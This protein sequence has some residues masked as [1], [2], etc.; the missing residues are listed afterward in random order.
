MS[1]PVVSYA[2]GR[3]DRAAA[4][5]VDPLWLDDTRRH[6]DSRVVPMWHDKCLVAGSDPIIA[7]T[8]DAQALL[9]APWVFLGLDGAGG[10]FAAD[11]SAFDESDA[12]RLTGASGALD[13]RHLVGSLTGPTSS[14]IAHARG[15]LYWHRNQHFCGRCGSATESSASG[16]VRTCTGETCGRLLFPRIEPAVIALVESPTDPAR[17]LLGRANGADEDSFCTLAGFVEMGESL[18]DAVRREVAEEAGVQVGSVTYQASQPWP[19]PSGLMVGFRARALTEEIMVDGDELVEA[20]W[21]TKDE[22]REQ[23]ADPL[24]P[25]FKDDSIERVLLETW[26]DEA[27]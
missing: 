24:H 14:I 6:P 11:L 1:D 27:D 5:R 21:F 26:L 7:P 20:R 8:V 13:V 18:E 16:Q 22:L 25:L 2:G 17:C 23:A 10:V 9:A 3:L 19:F 12:L 4:H 15:L